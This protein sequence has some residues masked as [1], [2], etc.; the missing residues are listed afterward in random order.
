MSHSMLRLAVAAAV[1]AVLATAA[2]KAASANFAPLLGAWK[3]RGEV[4]LEGGTTEA[5][6]C[7]AY[8]TAKDGGNGLGLAIRCAS[9]SYK[10][11]LRS[12][13]TSQGNQVSGS[14]EERNFNAVG[15]VTGRATPGNISLQIDGGGLAGSMSIATE[16]AN[17]TVSISTSGTQLRG[18]SIKLSKT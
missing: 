16:G 4:R 10:I 6:S 15:N 9:Q 12:S 7:N 18:V 17:Q 3:G 14:W 11:E 5:I 2:A 13:L 8:Y 1:A